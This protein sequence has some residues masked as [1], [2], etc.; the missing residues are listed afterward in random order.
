MKFYRN[1][2]VGASVKNINKIKWKLLTGAGQFGVYV[3]SLSHTADQ[4]DIFH[5]AMLKQ[6]AFD[7]KSLSV[8]GIAG[9]M[10]EAYTLV[11]QMVQD[12]LAAGFEGNVKAY[13]AETFRAGKGG[14]G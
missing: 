2:Y 9:D 7:K 12:G 6:K 8:V 3:I 11:E 4:L 5:C 14:G 1:L 13:L 10:G